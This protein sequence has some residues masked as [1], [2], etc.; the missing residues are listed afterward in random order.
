VFW[1]FTI[2]MAHGLKL[3][4]MLL[5]QEYLG[6]L[7]HYEQNTRIIKFKHK[8]DVLIITSN[9]NGLLLQQVKLMLTVGEVV[10]FII[11][12]IIIIKAV[13]RLLSIF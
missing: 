6:S 1:L 7:G 3:L 2:K 5:L 4:T 8:R 9:S 12:I 10:G 13:L 11:I